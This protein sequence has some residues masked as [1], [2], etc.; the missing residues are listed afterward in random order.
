[1]AKAEPALAT[2]H[3]RRLVAPIGLAVF[4]ASFALFHYVVPVSA[5]VASAPAPAVSVFFA[6]LATVLAMALAGAILAR[7]MQVHN[8][9]TCVALNNMSQGLC[10]FDGNERLVVTSPSP[11][12]RSRACSNSA[13]PTVPSRA[14]RSNTDA[15][16]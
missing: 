13:S 3:D 9:R 14:I 2:W 8:Q 15:N 11:A 10:M 4:A 6:A 5:W 1:M 7:R 16:C 12:A